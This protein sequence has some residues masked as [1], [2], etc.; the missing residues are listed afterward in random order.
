MQARSIPKHI[1][2][3]LDTLTEHHPA[4]HTRGDGDVILS[5][6]L[7]AA[8]L[9]VYMYSNSCSMFLRNVVNVCR[10]AN[11]CVCVCVKFIS[12]LVETSRHRHRDFQIMA[13]KS[14]PPRMPPPWRRGFML[15][16]TTSLHLMYMPGCTVTY[17]TKSMQ[18]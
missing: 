15:N 1:L 11:C 17:H 13:S 12:L 14:L 4:E 6:I 16:S 3:A 10:R 5:A 7:T 8:M 18:Q 2:S 9:E